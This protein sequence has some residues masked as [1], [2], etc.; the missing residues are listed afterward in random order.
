MFLHSLSL[1]LYLFI[2][3]S[4]SLCFT[5]IYSHTCVCKPIDIYIYVYVHMLLAQKLFSYSQST[6]DFRMLLRSRGSEVEGLGRFWDLGA[7]IVQ[8][9]VTRMRGLTALSVHI[10]SIIMRI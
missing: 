1:S 3:L 7:G 10:M 6:D 4:L 9:A 5:Y 2:A 8:R